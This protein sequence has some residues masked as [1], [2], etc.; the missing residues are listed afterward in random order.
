MLKGLAPPG[1]LHSC[2]SLAPARGPCALLA[3]CTSEHFFCHQDALF[4]AKQGR[5]VACGLRCASLA[6]RQSG[7]MTGKVLQLSSTAPQVRTLLGEL[8]CTVRASAVG[9][10]W[11]RD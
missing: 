4:L 10:Y 5:V 8:L 6:A 9:A 11:P 2:M 3:A 1:S 7:G